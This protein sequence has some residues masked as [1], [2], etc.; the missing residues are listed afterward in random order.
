MRWHGIL[1]DVGHGVSVM[2]EAEM[3]EVRG[4]LFGREQRLRKRDGGSLR[5][6]IMRI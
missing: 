6:P 1:G 2:S 4:T 3:G 5:Y